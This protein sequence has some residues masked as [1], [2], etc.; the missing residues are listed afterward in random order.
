MKQ[1]DGIICF[2]KTNNYFNLPVQYKSKFKK[3]P[4]VY[5]ADE[6]QPKIKNGDP[7]FICR[8]SGKYGVFQWLLLSAPRQILSKN[9]SNGLL[10]FE[11][12]CSNGTKTC[13]RSKNLA[14]STGDGFRIR[15]YITLHK[16]HAI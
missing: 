14:P 11:T 9:C 10:F 13:S 15:S 16:F 8:A 5:L 6:C 12:G 1:L 4:R 7:P 2:W 3:Q